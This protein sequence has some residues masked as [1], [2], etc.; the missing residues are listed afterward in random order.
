MNSRHFLRISTQLDISEIQTTTNSIEISMR[1]QIRHEITSA[2]RSKLEFSRHA[3]RSH[4]LEEVLIL[5][6][7]WRDV[8][9][10]EKS[11]VELNS[12]RTTA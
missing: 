7:G 11:I 4:L 6:C 3:R 8:Q 1:M 12:T 5:A 10:W 9:N 2:R